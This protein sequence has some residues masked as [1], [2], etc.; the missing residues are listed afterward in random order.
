LDPGLQG[1]QAGLGMREGSKLTGGYTQVMINGMA[2]STVHGR[3]NTSK[4]KRYQGAFLGS[5][6]PNNTWIHVCSGCYVVSILSSTPASSA[7]FSF[8]APASA[9]PGTVTWAVSGVSSSK[10]STTSAIGVSAAASTILVSSPSSWS[11]RVRSRPAG[12]AV[13][14]PTRLPGPDRVPDGNGLGFS[15]SVSP[16]SS[17]PGC[18]GVRLPL[19]E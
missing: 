16:A 1:L 18:A 11:S 10:A 9:G 4:G 5:G 17:S 7:P 8:T 2:T 15:P 3:T 13:R 14:L 19:E 12:D 6:P